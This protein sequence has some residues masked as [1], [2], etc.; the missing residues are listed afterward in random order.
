M[1]KKIISDYNIED[2]EEEQEAIRLKH[3]LLKNGYTSSIQDCWNVWADVS[4]D[5][6]AN[7]LCM[8]DDDDE[9]WEKVRYKVIEM[10]GK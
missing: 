6:C 1:I 9:V 8:S 5:Y 10:E 2:I 4:E 7:W 3:I